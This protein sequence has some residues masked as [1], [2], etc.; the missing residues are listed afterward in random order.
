M[1]G[2]GGGQPR[3]APPLPQI[4]ASGSTFADVITGVW[5]RPAARVPFAAMAAMAAG[6]C[7]STMGSVA[8]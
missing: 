7:C 2:R 4:R 3:R 8:V 6:T 1:R 5:A